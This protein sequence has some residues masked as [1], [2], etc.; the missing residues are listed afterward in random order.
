MEGD[1]FNTE[2]VM[3]ICGECDF[4]LKAFNSQL[5][6]YSGSAVES[7]ADISLE[8]CY[9]FSIKIYFRSSTIR[10]NL[11]TPAQTVVY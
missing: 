1:D 4:F 2:A 5:Y 6:I 11:T 3:N 10:T 9:D 8:T 7:P